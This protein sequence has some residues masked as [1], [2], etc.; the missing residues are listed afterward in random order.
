[1]CGDSNVQSGK[2]IRDCLRMMVEFSFV[3]VLQW[4]PLLLE[5]NGIVSLPKNLCVL[6]RRTIANM[7]PLGTLTR[8]RAISIWLYMLAIEAPKLQTS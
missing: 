7:G 4:R 8:S 6:K 3:K 2:T 5:T 1:M